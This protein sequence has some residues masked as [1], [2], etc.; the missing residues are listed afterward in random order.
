MPPLSPKNS[1]ERRP[2]PE[3]VLQA[4]AAEPAATLVSASPDPQPPIAAGVDRAPAAIRSAS[5]DLDALE[6]AACKRPRNQLQGLGRLS[7]PPQGGAAGLR[8]PTSPATSGAPASTSPRTPRLAGQSPAAPLDSPDG[9]LREELHNHFGGILSGHDVLRLLFDL[10]LDALKS[11]TSR[12]SAAENDQIQAAFKAAREG[13]AIRI[14]RRLGDDKT[15]ASRQAGVLAA[16]FS[17]RLAAGERMQAG[18]IKPTIDWPAA[19]VLRDMIGMLEHFDAATTLAGKVLVLEHSLEAQTAPKPTASRAGRDL[20]AASLPR[21][22]FDAAYAVRGA[23]LKSAKDFWRQKLAM[24]NPPIPYIPTDESDQIIRQFL[25]AENASCPLVFSNSEKQISASEKEALEEACAKFLTDGRHPLRIR[26]DVDFVGCKNV[27]ESEDPGLVFEMDKIIQAKIVQNAGGITR[28]GF[29]LEYTPAARQLLYID[30]IFQTL[31]QAPNRL[32]KVQLQ[33]GLEKFDLPAAMVARLAQRHGL[34]VGW[35]RIISND[36]DHAERS[37][38][39]HIWGRSWG[40]PRVGMSFQTPYPPRGAPCL[41]YLPMIPPH[42]PFQ[43]LMLHL[44][45]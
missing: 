32:G 9:P 26:L 24:G 2:S 34:E 45:A 36:T 35:V 41:Q 44:T 42:K 38:I 3:P 4:T 21:N 23:L 18:Q 25:S 6:R 39:L 8:R 19:Q 33:G 15:V 27:E 14:S 43:R 11:P 28:E 29:A 20:Q 7:V 31:R 13:L 1:P 17:I 10:N 22:H 30:K 37:R 5:N 16:Q 40:R 12:P